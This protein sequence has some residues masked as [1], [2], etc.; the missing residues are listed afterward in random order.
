[1]V[2]ILQP[3]VRNL[4]LLDER[5]VDEERDFLAS[6]DA[7]LYPLEEPVEDFGASKADAHLVQ[8]TNIDVVIVLAFCSRSPGSLD[9][10]TISPKDEV[11]EFLAHSHRPGILT[12]IAP[13]ESG[14]DV[15]AA[16][17]TCLCVTSDDGHLATSVTVGFH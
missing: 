10:H 7:L 5:I 12:R 3:I 4:G 1:M 14:E 11:A 13:L 2:G 15:R 17:A 16:L 6:L 8:Q 9:L